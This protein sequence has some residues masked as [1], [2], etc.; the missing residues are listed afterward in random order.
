MTRGR[1]ISSEPWKRLVSEVEDTI[2]SSLQ[3][4]E[5]DLEFGPRLSA[6]RDLEEQIA[7]LEEILHHL[8]Q[9]GSVHGFLVRVIHRDWVRYVES[10]AVNGHPPRNKEEIQALLDKARLEKRWEALAARWSR[11]VTAS[12]GPH[13]IDFGSRPESAYRQ[14]ADIVRSGMNW[15]GERWEPLAE[16]MTALRLRWN[17]CL[18]STPPVTHGCGEKL[19]ACGTPSN[20]DCCP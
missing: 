15:R 17:E 14:Y 8:D 16:G 11:Q 5:A 1:K 18:N 20:C 3:F 19:S 4:R 10:V 13:S 7:R 2:Q 6:G 12:G 9:G